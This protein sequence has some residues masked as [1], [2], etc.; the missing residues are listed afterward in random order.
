MTKDEN[1]DLS[2]VQQRVKHGGQQDDGVLVI[3]TIAMAS[4]TNPA[5]EFAGPK[6][7]AKRNSQ[8]IHVR[9]FNKSR[10]R[11]VISQQHVL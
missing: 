7:R 11:F 5:G 1:D 4:N 2:V 8:R 9:K 3:R 6:R 10:G